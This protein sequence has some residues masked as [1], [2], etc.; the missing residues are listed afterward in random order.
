LLVLAWCVASLIVALVASSLIAPSFLV[1]IAF[2]PATLLV[3]EL[4]HRVDFKASAL[5]A[6]IAIFGARGAIAI[7]NPTTVLFSSADAQAMEWI[8]ANTPADAKFLANTF[9]WYGEYVVP[10]DGGAWIPY[11]AQRPVELATERS[12]GADADTLAEWCAAKQISYVYLGWRAGELATSMFA[13]QPERFT[14]VYDR[15]G[16]RIYR[17]WLSNAR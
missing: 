7:I 3:A 15:A 2:I 6:L 14:L 10:A 17:H 11:A 16:V 8:R 1:L 13:A 4:A 5:I 9:Q 12:L